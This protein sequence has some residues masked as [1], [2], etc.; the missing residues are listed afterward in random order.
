MAALWITTLVWAIVCHE[1]VLPNAGIDIGRSG[2]VDERRFYVT[3]MGNENPV[4][5]QDYLDYPRM[6]VMVEMIDKYHA[7][8]G[9]ILPSSSYDEWYVARMPGVM[10]KGHP[11]QVTVYF[12]NLGMTSMNVPLDVRV[13]WEADDA[14]RFVHEALAM[15]VGTVIAIML[16][17][18]MWLVP[19]WTAILVGWY[20]LG[21]PW[22]F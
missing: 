19:I 16:P 7:E 20:L 22:G 3:N 9:V 8:G 6:R 2:I 17:Y 18:T 11:R 4:T 12:L 5:A 1:K 14:G 10:P 15:G 21:I 13:T